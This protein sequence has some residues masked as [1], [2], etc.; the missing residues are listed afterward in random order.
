M[1]HGEP[2]LPGR[3]PAVTLVG[4]AS[5]AA[6]T[7]SPSCARSRGSSRVLRPS[8]IA[9]DVRTTV[10][11][12]YGETSSEKSNELLKHMGLA[13]LS[14][15]L[16]MAFALG[17]REAGVVLL[18][19]PV[20]LALTL[21]VFAPLRLH[22]EPHHALR[23]DLLDRNPRRRRDRR[24]REHRAAPAACPARA[25]GR[26]RTS[27]SRRPTRWAIRPSSR[28]SPSSPRSCPMGFVG[29]L[30]GPY[31]RPIPIGASAAML[32]S[33]ARRLQRLSLGDAPALPARA[34]SGSAGIARETR[35]TL[36]APLP[37][38]DDAARRPREEAAPGS[39]SSPPSRSC[40]SRPC[41]LVPLGL[42]R[43]K[44]L[45][46]DNK[47]EFQVVVDFPEGTTLETTNARA[48]GDGRRA[49]VALAGGRRDGGVRGH[50]GAVQLQ[51]PR[52]ALFP[53]LR[54]RTRATS[55]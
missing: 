33:L 28:P 25:A 23:P 12:D 27:R 26:S 22:A 1:T 24:R 52:P 49:A 37:P 42:V 50:G 45:P 11:R 21:F 9:S 53:A 16:L 43:V 29:G 48:L 41:A 7:R 34:A 32:F 6:P 2:G 14:V 31:M 38:R 44:M 46:F 30:M 55:R 4:L 5:A 13:T 54:R 10:T 20:T 36:G 35:G 17:R 8:L 15:A 51:R 19:V 39:S 3:F 18:A 40:S 47:N